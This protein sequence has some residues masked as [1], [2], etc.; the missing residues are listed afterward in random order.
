[1]AILKAPGLSSHDVVNQARRALKLKRVGHTGTLDPLAA[2]VMVLLVGRATRVSRYFT[3]LPKQY[4]VE[5][6]FG[7]RTS[8]GDADGQVISTQDAGHLTESDVETAMGEF[9]GTI[10]QRPPLTS[11]VKVGGQPL[12]KLARKG[13]KVEAPP[14]QVKIYE[15][16]LLKWQPSNRPRA[17][18]HVHC[19]SGTYIRSL[20]D[21]LG[22]KLQVGASVSFLLRTAVG[23]FHAEQCV[24]REELE[25]AADAGQIRDLVVPLVDALSFLPKVEVAPRLIDHIAHGRPIQFPAD[26]PA[27]LALPSPDTPFCLVDSHRRLLAIAKLKRQSRQQFQVN[28]ELVLV[29]PQEVKRWGTMTP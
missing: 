25:A 5:A 1:M 6:I 2:G 27:I 21:D 8:S 20:I 4:R 15:F 28:Y 18:F 9:T 22:Q 3:N 29:T 10:T 19:S 16:D 7:V 11:A 26:M 17:I 23:P 13:I 14:R 12:Y 24:T